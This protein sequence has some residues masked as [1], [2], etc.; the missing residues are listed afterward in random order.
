MSTERPEQE[1]K[2]GCEGFHSRLRTLLK[3]FKSNNAFAVAAGI[4]PSGLNRLLEGGYP[5]LPILIALAKAGG[6]C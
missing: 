1:N 5:T 2:L 4:S 6:I 3:K